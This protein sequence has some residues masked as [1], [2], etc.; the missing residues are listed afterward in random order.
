MASWL[1]EAAIT[2]RSTSF[3]S[4]SPE[5]LPAFLPCRPA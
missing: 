5:D 3:G 4:S 1:V 2:D